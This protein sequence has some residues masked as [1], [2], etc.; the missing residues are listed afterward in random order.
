MKT[1]IALLAL[2]LGVS[3]PLATATAAERD[4]ALTSNTDLSG[5]EEEAGLCL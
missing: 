1:T 5:C 4:A 2:A 3:A